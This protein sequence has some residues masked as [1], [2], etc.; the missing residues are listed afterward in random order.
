MAN[1]QDIFIDQ[2][3]DFSAQVTVKRDGLD[4]DLTGYTLEAQI[5]KTMNASSSIVSF[6]VLLNSDNSNVVE[7]FLSSA[8]TTTL[9]SKRYVYDL[10]ATKDGNT[11]RLIQGHITVSPNV[12]R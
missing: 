5:R 4:F 7:L 10:E 2:G 12:T 11:Y 3:A 9:E 6:S 1:S 8:Q